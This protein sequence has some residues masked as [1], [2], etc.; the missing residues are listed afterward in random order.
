VD[1][2]PTE[3]F[4]GATLDQRTP[5]LVTTNAQGLAP[6][7]FALQLPTNATTGFVN[8]T[9]T[10][11]N[12]GDTSELSPC[13]QIGACTFQV[14]PTAQSVPSAGGNFNFAVTA[15]AGCNW[16]AS[17]GTNDWITINTGTGTGNGAV[18]F[19]VAANASATPRSGAITVGTATHT[20]NQ[21]GAT[22]CTFQIN[23]TGANFAAAGGQGNFAIS[24]QAGCQWAENA[25]DNWITITA[26][27]NGTGNGNINYSVQQN[28]SANPRTGFI[29]AG[30]QTYTITQTG[31]AAGPTVTSAF[32]E[33]KH[34]IVLGTGF[35]DGAKVLRNGEQIKTALELDTRLFCKKQ[36]KS[37]VAGDQIQVRNPDG[38][39]SN[40]VTYPFN[41]P[42]ATP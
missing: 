28:A 42:P 27:A 2:R 26:G 14:N 7:T 32:R 4:N 1:C 12:T 41:A 29:F 21:S 40:V 39:L 33:G 11:Q 16:T 22:N 18:T 30:G 20:D 3:L 23:P 15:T 35:Q 25:S 37:S 9:A 34:L 19:T 13:N 24:T 10:R 6:F 8:C 38:T 17:R 36:G 5:N 31:T